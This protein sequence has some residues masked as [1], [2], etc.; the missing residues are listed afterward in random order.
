MVTCE[1]I[2]VSPSAYTSTMAHLPYICSSES[3]QLK[4]GFE[5]AAQDEARRRTQAATGDVQNTEGGR[6][7]GRNSRVSEWPP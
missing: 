1:H 5:R 7:G 3:P 2:V 4:T 6:V